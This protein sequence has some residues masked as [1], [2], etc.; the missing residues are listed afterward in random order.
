MT[1]KDGNLL[2]Y[3]EY[4]GKGRLKEETKVADSAYQPFRLQNQYAYRGAGLHYNCF[5]YYEP[6][7]DRFVNQD[8]IGLLSGDNLYAFARI[9]RR[10]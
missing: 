6:D 2:W 10:G 3:G 1:D 9:R 7:E 5:R 4:T 8:P